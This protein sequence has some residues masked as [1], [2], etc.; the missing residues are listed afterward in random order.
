MC[1]EGCTHGECVYI[2]PGH[3]FATWPTDDQATTDAIMEALA[4]RGIHR[5]TE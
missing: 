2:P 3:A 5:G 1:D 4:E